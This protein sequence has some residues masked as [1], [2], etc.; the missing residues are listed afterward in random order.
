[1]AHET[2]RPPHRHGR[3]T[4]GEGNRKRPCPF[5]VSREQRP[6]PCAFSR[7]L[8]SLC[9]CKQAD[10][11]RQGWRPPSRPAAVDRDGKAS[12][13]SAGTVSARRQAGYLQAAAAELCSSK[14][15]L[16]LLQRQALVTAPITP[17]EVRQLLLI[18]IRLLQSVAAAE[19]SSTSLSNSETACRSAEFTGTKAGRQAGRLPH[20]GRL[21]QLN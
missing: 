10:E 11:S 12:R 7:R 4:S 2:A 20:A 8:C 3:P 14:L 1:M 18:A 6:C 13:S 15:R 19:F 17:L 16:P 5:P 9:G 21:P